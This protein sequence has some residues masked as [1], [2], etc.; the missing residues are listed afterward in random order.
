M[1]K[2]VRFI[3]GDE[4]IGSYIEGTD[5]KFSMRDIAVIHMMPGQGGQVN[6]GLLPFAPYAEELTLDFK[7]STVTTIFTPNRELL[8][9]YNRLFGSG[10]VVP[11]SA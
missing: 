5:D 6:L 3:N 4:L 1:I 2:I 9:N 10:L 11:P 7:H 8:N